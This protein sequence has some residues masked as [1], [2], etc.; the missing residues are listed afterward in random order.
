MGPFTPVLTRYDTKTRI[1]SMVSFWVSGGAVDFQVASFAFLGLNP[2]HGDRDCNKDSYHQWI[3]R[4]L[5]GR[6]SIQSPNWQLIF[7]LTSG[8][9]KSQWN[10]PILNRQYIFRESVFHCYVRLPGVLLRICSGIYIYIAFRMVQR[11]TLIET[12]WST[13]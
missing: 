7:H 10:S 11:T 9:L 5:V 3:F 12:P 1:I 13:H 4:L 6:C 2:T 8:K